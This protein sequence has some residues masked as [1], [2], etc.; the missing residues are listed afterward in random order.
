MLRL[1]RSAPLPLALALVAITACGDTDSAAADTDGTDDGAQDGD[2]DGDDGQ[3]ADGGSDGDTGGGAASAVGR[4]EYVSPFTQ[5]AECRQYF[6]DG[7]DEASLQ[8]ECG[9]LSGELVMGSRCDEDGTLG[10]CLL[11]DDPERTIEIL[12]YG[13]DAGS[14]S[15]QAVGCESFGGGTWEP[16]GVCRGTD[17]P[18]PPTGGNVFIQP[19]LVC[20]DAIA[21]EPEG[22]T[23]GQVCTWEAI[24]GCTEEGRRFSDYASCDNV[25]TQR[26]YYPA[27]AASE[28]AEPDPRLEDEAYAAELSWVADQVAAS[29][30]VCC[31]S[32][33][34]APNGPSNWYLEAPGNWMDSFYD[35]GLAMSAGWV[36]STAFGAYP[37]QDNN[38]FHR[39][40]VGLPSTDPERMIAFFVGELEHRGLTPDDFTDTKP[41]GGPLYDQLIYEPEACAEGEGV[42]TD[43]SVR[44][45]GGAARY[46]YVLEAGSDNP[47]VPPNLDLPEGTLWR[48]DVPS[49]GTPISAG[50]VTYGQIPAGTS[51]RIPQDGT[52]PALTEGTE[53]YLYVTA[54]VGIPMTRC[55]FR[56]GE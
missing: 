48:I 14:C 21:G 50:D 35:S 47:T 40:V 53:Y 11:N 31:H 27:P 10:T 6:G 38:G 15:T 17:D 24:S 32:T 19:T 1:P 16:S 36:D 4:C 46:V 2:V 34:E 55:T 39:D 22:L 30:C 7:W 13:D 28:P 12:A 37:S 29:A 51:Q 43:G 26:P 8:D 42:F 3:P 23:D 5:G 49:D 25:L 18:P 54:D 56:Y 9:G 52:P 41:F 33:N 20:R 44:W 45:Q